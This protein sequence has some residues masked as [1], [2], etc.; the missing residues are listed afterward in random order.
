MLP[1]DMKSSVSAQHSFSRCLVVALIA[2][3]NLFSTIP[4]MN[5]APEAKTTPPAKTQLA[6]FGGGC[7]WCLEALFETFDGVKAVVSGYAGGKTANPTYKEICGGDTGHAEV[8]QVEFDPA[9]ISYGQLLEI[10]WD[11]HDPTALNRQSADVGTQYRSV[12]YTHDDAQKAAAG[13]SKQAAG[14]KFKT[15]ITTEIA[16]LK[17]FYIAEEYHQ[18]YFRKNPNVPYCAYV[19]SPKLQKLQKNKYGK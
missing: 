15:P 14:A 10:F 13:K 17:K 3:L 11:I 12:I 2:L 16:P 7:F 1:A 9:K 18:D 8:V 6:T 5:A 19:I 4:L